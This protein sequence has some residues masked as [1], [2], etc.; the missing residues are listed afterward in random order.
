MFSVSGRQAESLGDSILAN[1]S[2]QGG[3]ERRSTPPN[4]ELGA[5]HDTPAESPVS[6]RQTTALHE[7]ERSDPVEIRAKNREA[8]VGDVVGFR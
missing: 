6:G 4:R 7:E 8:H 3:V 1:R 2:R 5:A